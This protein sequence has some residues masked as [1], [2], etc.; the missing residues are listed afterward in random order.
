MR[1]KSLWPNN[2]GIVVV[3]L[4]LH[5]GPAVLKEKINTWKD[6]YG[7]EERYKA[8]FCGDKHYNL[9]TTI[10]IGYEVNSE[11]T[12]FRKWANTIIE[13]FTIKGYPHLSVIHMVT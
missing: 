9:A 10:A 4:N 6:V 12:R 11:R 5:F 8:K 2:E 7:I 3:P 13:T 1:V